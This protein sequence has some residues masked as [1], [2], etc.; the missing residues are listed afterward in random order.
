MDKVGNFLGSDFVKNGVKEMM[1]MRPPDNADLIWKHPDRTIPAFAQATVN[2]D[3]WGVFSKEGRPVGTLDAGRWTLST[4]NIPFLS[5]FVDQ[6]T[7][8]N[9]FTTDLYFVKRIPV[10]MKFGGNL[11]NMIDPLTQIRVRGRCHGSLLVR[12][13]NPEVLIYQYFGMRKFQEHPDIFD[14]FKDAFFN[15]VKSTIGKFAREQSRT[16]LDIMDA[17]DDLAAAFVQNSAELA[18]VGMRIVKVTKFECDIPEEDIKR[19]D[20]ANQ[21]I[22]EARRGVGI[23]ALKAQA[24]AAAAQV[25]VQTADFKAQAEQFKIN[26]ELGRVQAMVGM[27]GGD[28]SKLGSYNAMTGAGA[29]LAQGGGNTGL[30]GMGAQI[31]VGAALGSNL[32]AGAMVGAPRGA[33]PAGAPAM[34]VGVALLAC[35]GCAAQVPPGRF[36]AE[37][38]TALQAAKKRCT[39][40]NVELAPNARFC[41]ECGTAAGAAPPSAG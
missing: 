3:E 19:F 38:G 8:G 11:G 22:A 34:G 41:A 14:W 25:G 32:A 17:Q 27:A 1:I 15:T 20:E 40:C 5:N 28:I 31:A 24:E 12:V 4:T 18:A 16:I 35:P 9:I 7:G 21:Q 36:C 26:Q 2:S 6:Y 13:E 33:A 30:A 10:E 29:G 39:G 37:C 23:A